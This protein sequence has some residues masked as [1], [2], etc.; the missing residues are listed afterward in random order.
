VLAPASSYEAAMHKDLNARRE[1]FVREYLA[2]R[3]AAARIASAYGQRAEA[4]VS[5]D[6]EGRPDSVPVA[7]IVTSPAALRRHPP[8]SP[9]PLGY[10]PQWLGP[11]QRPRYATLAG[12]C[13][14]G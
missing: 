9:Y 10:N 2:D 6:R 3:N 5:R 8:L 7:A 4:D 11:P 13:D 1:R 14:R 12:E